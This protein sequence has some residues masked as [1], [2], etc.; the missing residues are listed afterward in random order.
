VVTAIV[1]GLA[2]AL[3][4]AGGELVNPLRDS[5]K[6]TSGGYRGGRLSRALVVGEVALSLVLLAGAGLLMRS[7]LA[8][9]TVDLG[10]DVE[11][12]L[13]APMSLGASQHKTAAAE[14]RFLSQVLARV[15]AV[16]GVLGATTTTGLPVYGGWENEIEIPGVTLDDPSR[17]LIQLCSDG[18]FQTL[19]IRLL[20]G[21]D[22]TPQDLADARR[23]AVVN[24]A[25]V[26]RYLSGRDPIGRRFK[27]KTQALQIAPED[28]GFEIVGVVAD[29]KNRGIQDPPFPEAVVPSSSAKTVAHGLVVRTTGPPLA[30]LERV[31]REIWAVDRGVSVGSSRTLSEYLKQ[32]SYAEPRLG[33]YIFG[34]FAG[35]GLA[36]VILGV[37]SVIAYNV[38][39]QTQEIG[40]RMALG[41]ARGD[42]LKMT[43]RTGL[44]LVALGVII[45]VSVSL[46]AT[47]VLASQLW[48]VS[49]SDP[50]TLGVV[51]AIV[52]LAGLGA[53]YFPALRATRVD[54]MIV[55]RS[56]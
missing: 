33:L 46:A 40:I 9:Q 4:A 22:L 28:P 18:Y 32:F 19:G 47:R 36:L 1:F 56:E 25:F 7:F 26:E 30:M 5:G 39:R 44:H 20:Q 51:A 52:T 13:Y 50:V 16:P 27:V 53:S 29:A 41:A 34:A 8:L 17:A 49:P 54:P 15:R 31:K 55:L 24:R 3:Q 43:L 2:P 6:G 35:L 14:T 45:G 10:L 12:V 38:S 42:V 37:Y 11:N 48:A 21:R 23:V